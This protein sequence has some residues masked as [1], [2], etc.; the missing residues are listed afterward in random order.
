MKLAQAHANKKFQEQQGSLSSKWSSIEKAL[1]AYKVPFPALLL[2]I[3]RIII[4][5]TLK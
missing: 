1:E 5:S 3:S 4:I 2:V